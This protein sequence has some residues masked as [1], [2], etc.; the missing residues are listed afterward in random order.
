MDK[1]KKA[2]KE[3]LLGP[4]K[5]LPLSKDTSNEKGVAL[6][7]APGQAKPP[8]MTKEVTKG[9]DAASAKVPEPSAQPAVKND[10][11]P[12]RTN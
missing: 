12:P 10:P 11:L 4:T 9:K 8:L 1:G 7:Q 3:K 5:P 2:T 6:S